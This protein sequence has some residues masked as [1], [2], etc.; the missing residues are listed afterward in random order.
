M[1]T[2]LEQY[3]KTLKDFLSLQN[4]PQQETISKYS[5]LINEFLIID[6]E[7]EETRRKINEENLK[8]FPVLLNEFIDRKKELRQELRFTAPEI[9]I[10]DILKFTYDEVRHSKFLGWLLNP[11]ETHSQGNLFFKI[12]LERFKRFGL[13]FAYAEDEDYDVELE[14]SEEQSRVDIRVSKKNEFCICIENKIFSGEGEEQTKREYEDA[15]R[16]INQN[17]IKKEN[18]HCFFLTIDGTKPQEEKFK[19]IKWSEIAKCIE[20]FIEKAEAERAKWT[21]EQYLQSI[22]KNIIKRED[23]E[24]GA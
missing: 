9:N 13:S 2:E 8:I 20:I 4:T 22:R 24:N 16:F 14:A 5:D 23:E 21:A 17:D 6:N 3:K 7:Q 10:L 15:I 19:S 1:K 18:L 12:F 11:E